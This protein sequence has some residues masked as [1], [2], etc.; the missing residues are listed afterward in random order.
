MMLN[1]TII[2]EL[3]CLME[4][5]VC[6]KFHVSDK[7]SGNK[8]ALPTEE[9]SSVKGILVAFSGLSYRLDRVV[10]KEI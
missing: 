9:I 5:K 10:A 2:N 4:E 1:S 7:D 6:D 8:A 3:I